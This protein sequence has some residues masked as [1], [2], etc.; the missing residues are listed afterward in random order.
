MTQPERPVRIIRTDY[1][2][3]SLDS[4]LVGQDAVVSAL[5]WGA[6]QNAQT[7]L[8][9]SAAA[10]WSSESRDGIQRFIPSEFGM[11]NLD[12]KGH[13]EIVKMIQGRLRFRDKMIDTVTEIPQLS[14]TGIFTSLW[15]DWVSLQPFNI[16]HLSS[17]PRRRVKRTIA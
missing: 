13:P 16:W 10:S 12:I 7:K 8:L 14:Y 9:E 5:G 17:S 11:P 2:A 4:A 3:A 15:F 1:S 6:E